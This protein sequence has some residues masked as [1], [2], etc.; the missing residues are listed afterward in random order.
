ML[1]RWRYEHE[2]F[3]PIPIDGWE[4]VEFELSDGTSRWC[5]FVTPNH[6]RKLV[7]N[8]DPEAPPGT[9]LPKA[10]V[11]RSLEREVIDAMM[12]H[13]DREGELIEA[14]EPRESEPG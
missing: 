1:V 4:D 2:D 11:A 3:G 9:F 14:S 13:L 5:A 12:R 7:E 10:I 8:P 6:L